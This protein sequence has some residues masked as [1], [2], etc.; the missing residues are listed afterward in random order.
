MKTLITAL[1]YSI[2]TIGRIESLDQ[3]AVVTFSAP[4]IREKKSSTLIK[5]YEPFTLALR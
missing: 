4:E 1:K 2:P 5:I 3:N